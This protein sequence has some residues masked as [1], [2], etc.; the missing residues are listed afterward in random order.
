MRR[1]FGLGDG[2]NLGHLGLG[3]G[4]AIDGLFGNWRVCE[5]RGVVWTVSG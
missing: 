1:H 4:V 2:P 5:R 3:G